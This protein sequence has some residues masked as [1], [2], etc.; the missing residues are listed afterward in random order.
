VKPAISDR[1]GDAVAGRASRS[2]FALIA[3]ASSAVPSLNFRLGLS[4]IVHTVES[5]LPVTELA[6][7]GVITCV[8]G[9]M[10]RSSSYT[11]WTSGPNVD[12]P[13]PSLLSKLVASELRSQTTLPP[14]VGFVPVAARDG[15]AAAATIPIVVSATSRD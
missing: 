9:S 2:Q 7:P 8:T 11:A 15:T 6:R 1:A 3:L 4:L 5:A 13:L 12:V 14:F 10:W